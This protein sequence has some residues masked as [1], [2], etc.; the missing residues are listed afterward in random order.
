[1]K[2][3]KKKAIYQALANLLMWFCVPIVLGLREWAK[4]TAPKTPFPKDELLKLVEPTQLLIFL[5]AGAIY[6][7]LFAFIRHTSRKK[8]EQDRATFFA[9]LGFD[10]MASALFSFGSVLLVC[11][12]IGAPWWYALISIVCYGVGYFLKPEEETANPSLQGTA[13]GG[14]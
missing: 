7:S 13:S 12:F 3:T 11:A 14:P 10:E 4:G 2:F 5:A 6:F 8:D 1:M 9:D